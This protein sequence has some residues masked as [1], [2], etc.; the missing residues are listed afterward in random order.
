MQHFSIY[1][2]SY[3]SR[4]ESRNWFNTNVNT[5]EAGVLLHFNSLKVRSLVHA[6]RVPLG[7]IERDSN[8]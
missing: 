3:I 5:E 6:L 2:H 4:I 8:V 7:S 1:L